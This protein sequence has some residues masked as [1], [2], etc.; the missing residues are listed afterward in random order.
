[1]LQQTK[2]NRRDGR[3]PDRCKALLYKIKENGLD[4]TS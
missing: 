3:N 2:W 4:K 1:M